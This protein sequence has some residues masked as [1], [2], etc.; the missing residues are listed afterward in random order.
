MGKSDPEKF[1]SIAESLTPAAHMDENPLAKLAWALGCPSVHSAG[2][3]WPEEYAHKLPLYSQGLF[4]SE[5]TY[6][7][8]R[9]ASWPSRNNGVYSVGFPLQ[10]YRPM[11]KQLSFAKGIF[12]LRF[13]YL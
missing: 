13:F 8:N 3:T 6:S 12:F 7:L 11:D 2:P 9:S 5:S 1:C 4:F 10:P